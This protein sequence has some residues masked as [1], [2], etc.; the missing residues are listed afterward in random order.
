MVA[1]GLGAAG[2]DT[3]CGG[4][5]ALGLTAV[6]QILVGQA[7]WLRALG[8]VAMVALGVA[9]I[10]PALRRSGRPG[11]VPRAGGRAGARLGCCFRL[12]TS[13]S[14]ALTPNS[15]R[16]LSHRPWGDDT[17]MESRVRLMAAPVAPRKRVRVHSGHKG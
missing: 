14:D 1:A 4:I 5:A 16:A 9:H 13:G 17:F 8:G 3:I 15:R 7:S 2:A 11:R 10:A 6:T 12:T